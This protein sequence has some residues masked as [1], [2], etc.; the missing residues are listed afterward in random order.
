[1]NYIDGQKCLDEI[2]A[3][4]TPEDEERFLL[5]VE[6]LKNYKGVVIGPI[7]EDWYGNCVDVFLT[8]NK[9]PG[10]YENYIY[11]WNSFDEAK[12]KIE[13]KENTSQRVFHVKEGLKI[14]FEHGMLVDECFSSQC[15]EFP[16]WYVLYNEWFDSR[17]DYLEMFI[18]DE[19]KE[20]R[21]REI[22][23][24]ADAFEKALSTFMNKE[25]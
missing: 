7:H 16:K 8:K 23:A 18:T 12:R 1:M 15:K 11:T 6:Y 5:S 24:V 14:A 25:H 4:V 13:G 17:G 3:A 22:L 2:L 21:S 19:D 10:K 20:K 9:F